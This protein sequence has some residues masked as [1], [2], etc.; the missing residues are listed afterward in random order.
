M[1][2]N[3][4]FR[5]ASVKGRQ[6]RV[7]ELQLNQL[8]RYFSAY[9]VDSHMIDDVEAMLVRGFANDLLNKKMERFEH[10]RIARRNKRRK[11]R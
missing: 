4:Q 7:T 11:A 1:E 2:G 6:P 9:E 10:A 3:T 8:A 5:S